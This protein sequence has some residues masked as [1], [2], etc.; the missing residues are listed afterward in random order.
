MMVIRINVH[1]ILRAREWERIR[2]IIYNRHS[3]R[4]KAHFFLHQYT[5]KIL[6]FKIFVFFDFFPLL[7]LLFV[8]SDGMLMILYP[9]PPL[10][11]L[12]S[13]FLSLSLI[14]YSSFSYISISIWCGLC[15]KI[16]NLDQSKILAS[17]Y[18]FLTGTNYVCYCVVCCNF[19]MKGCTPFHCHNSQFYL[20]YGLSWLEIC[21]IYFPISMGNAFE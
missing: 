12:C 17:S 8:F 4:W 19:N 2:R 5:R 15:V 6:Q 14:Q 9:F 18:F 3:I 20:W 13:D 7:L 11:K 21:S 16:W 1:W 10:L